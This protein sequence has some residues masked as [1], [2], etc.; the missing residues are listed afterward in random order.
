MAWR[1]AC[2][3]ALPAWHRTPQSVALKYSAISCISTQQTYRISIAPAA[4]LCPSSPAACLP[5]WRNSMGSRSAADGRQQA[6]HLR[7]HHAALA[8]SNVGG[9]AAGVT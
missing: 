2:S 1:A 4:K 6:S 3:L 9:M 5:R 8:L 7:W